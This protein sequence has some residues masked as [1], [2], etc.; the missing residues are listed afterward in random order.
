MMLDTAPTWVVLYVQA[1]CDRC[2]AMALE[3][4]KVATSLAGVVDVGVY[5]CAVNAAECRDRGLHMFPALAVY[6]APW[7]H[8]CEHP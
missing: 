2:D 4:Q 5:D 1:G 6:V 8:C 3:W 7:S